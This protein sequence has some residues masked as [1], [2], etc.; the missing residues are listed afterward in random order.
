MTDLERYLA[1]ATFSIS[2]EEVEESMVEWMHAAED[3]TMFR[4]KIALAISEDIERC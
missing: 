1:A 2:Q 3:L 4:E